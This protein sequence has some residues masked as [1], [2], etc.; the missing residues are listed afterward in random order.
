MSVQGVVAGGYTTVGQIVGTNEVRFRT[1]QN[2]L[3]VAV[4]LLASHISGAPVLDPNGRYV[5]FISE[6]DVLGAIESGKDLSKI[7]ADTIMSRHP[8]AVHDS[9]TIADAVKIME[10]HHLLNLPV[11]KNGTIGYSVTRHDL[12]RAWVGLGLDIEG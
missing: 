7:M 6:F 1:D 4:E 11:E 2:G 5:G 3:A 12:L 10:A 8:I 9:T